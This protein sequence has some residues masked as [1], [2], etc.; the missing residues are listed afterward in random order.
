MLPTLLP[1][2]GKKKA[3]PRGIGQAFSSHI[4]GAECRRGSKEPSFKN[5]IP[6]S[7]CPNPYGWIAKGTP[8][9]KMLAGTNVK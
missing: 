2:G 5:D 8:D 6:K 4:R 7:D 9:L 1:I 3:R